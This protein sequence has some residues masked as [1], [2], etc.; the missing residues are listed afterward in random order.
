MKAGRLSF[1]MKRKGLT[2]NIV[3]CY[4]AVIANENN[5][6]IFS[7]DEHFKSIKKFLKFELIVDL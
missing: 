2:V 7:L 6:K 4:I 3:D 5:C 1:S